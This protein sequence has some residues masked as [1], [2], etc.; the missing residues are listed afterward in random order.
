[1]F[2]T[3][4]CFCASKRW[5]LVSWTYAY[6]WFN[7]PRRR[8]EIYSRCFP[9]CLREDKLSH[10]SI[11]SSRVESWDYRRWYCLDE[12]RRRRKIVRYQPWGWFLW[13]CSGN[14]YG[15]QSKCNVKYSKEYNF[16]KRG[17][18]WGWWRLVGRY[19]IRGTWA[20][21]W[22]ERKRLEA[23]SRC[24]FSSP[25]CSFHC[26]SYPVSINC[27]WVGR[28]GWCSNFCD[29][30]RWPPSR[31]NSPGTWKFWLEPRCIHGFYHGFWD[32][33]SCDFSEYR[34]STSR[35]ICDVAILRISCLWIPPTLAKHGYK[36]RCRQIAQNILC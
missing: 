8:K 24:T 3:S 34:R 28:S 10:V 11:T 35:S 36:I 7:K 31:H 27:S 26:T 5:R 22:L 2:C 29:F 12:I 18:D 19:R 15:F 4:N 20:P 30:N 33:G 21:Y 23:G 14:F 32:Y 17:V 1:M 9:K 6:P 25:Q 13:C 16:H